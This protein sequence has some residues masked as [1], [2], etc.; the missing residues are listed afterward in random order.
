MGGEDVFCLF[1]MSVIS[2]SDKTGIASV[3]LLPVLIHKPSKNMNL[4]WSP[5]FFF[6]LYR[7]PSLTSDRADLESTE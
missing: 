2:R 5:S 1:E 6:T 4:C 3:I 7:L